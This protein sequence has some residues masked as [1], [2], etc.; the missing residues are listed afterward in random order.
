MI[1]AGWLQEVE[2]LLRS[3]VERSMQPMQ[4][5]GYKLLASYLNGEISLEYAVEQIKTSTRHFAKRQL[6]WYRKM[7]YIKWFQA[8]KLSPDELRTA[9]YN[10]ILTIHISML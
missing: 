8:D 6:T 7:P 4:A 10:M 9:V 1:A 5:I 3:G 2:N